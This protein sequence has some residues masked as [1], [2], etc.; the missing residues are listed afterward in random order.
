MTKVESIERSSSTTPEEYI[1]TNYSIIDSVSL[2]QIGEEP[3]E[4]Q[5]VLLNQMTP[6][7]RKS[8]ILERLDQ[9]KL[10]YSGI[11]QIFLN[12]LISF[13]SFQDSIYF[14]EF[15]HESINYYIESWVE[16]AFAIYQ[17]DSIQTLQL[18]TSF[19]PLNESPFF[20]DY[21]DFIP[22]PNPDD[23][24]KRCVCRRN[25][26]CNFLNDFDYDCVDYNCR[27]PWIGC[28]WLLLREC[29][30]RCH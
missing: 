1:N 11:Q 25:M 4:V 16:D 14:E 5:I 6:S 10:F 29:W 21:P 19:T 23:S 22:G 3:M 18:L 15:D 30:G 24:N 2:E 20:W 13:I 8:I 7:K 26:S 27:R 28:G 12:D 17:F 9:S